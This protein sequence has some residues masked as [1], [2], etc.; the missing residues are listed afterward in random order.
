LFY[1]IGPWYFPEIG[2]LAFTIKILTIVNDACAIKCALPQLV[3][4][5][6]TIDSQ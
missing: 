3:S 5:S 6:V 2:S 4:S 1:N